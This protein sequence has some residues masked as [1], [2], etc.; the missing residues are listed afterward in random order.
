MDDLDHG[1][2]LP[3]QDERELLAVGE[4][5]QPGLLQTM[6]IP[7]LAGRDFTERDERL[8][9]AAEGERDFRVAIVNERFA[10]HYFGNE[11]RG[12]TADRHGRQPEYANTD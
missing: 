9:P 3:G 6:G 8:A 4:L 2:G 10:R 5:D 7:L 12:R 1:R 11:Q